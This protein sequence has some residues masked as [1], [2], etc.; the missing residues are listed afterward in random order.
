MDELCELLRKSPGLAYQTKLPTDK[1][2]TNIG[3]WMV[4]GNDLLAIN[5]GGAGM[6][7]RAPAKCKQ[8]LSRLQHRQA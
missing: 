8:L 5:D 1:T 6:D 4:T 3:A 2:A 7:A